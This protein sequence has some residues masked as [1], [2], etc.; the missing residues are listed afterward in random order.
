MIEKKEICPNCESSGGQ[1]AKDCPQNPSSPIYQ[2]P[3]NPNNARL[4]VVEK[5]YHQRPN[6]DATVTQTSFSQSLN[7]KD[8]PY[9]REEVEVGKDWEKVDLGWIGAVK[10]GYIIIQ[11]MEKQGSANLLEVSFSNDL[12]TLLPTEPVCPG[13]L[14]FPRDSLRIYPL[15]PNVLR[16]RARVHNSDTIKYNLTVFSS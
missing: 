5:V 16:I 15:H 14:I 6:K 2:P 13:L 8:Q 3:D 9:V 4:T 1:H 10:C 12:E 11:N 7:Y